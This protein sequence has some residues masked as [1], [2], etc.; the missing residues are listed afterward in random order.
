MIVS[1]RI[2]EIVTWKGFSPVWTNWCLF[3]F[4]LSTKAF[5]HSAQ[6]CTRGPWV[7]RCFLMAEL[8]LNIFV[9]PFKTTQVNYLIVKAS[10]YQN[11]HHLN[12]YTLTR[13]TIILNQNMVWFWYT[14]KPKHGHCCLYDLILYEERLLGKISSFLKTGIKSF[15]FTT[16]MGSACQKFRK[17]RA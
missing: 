5:P 3:S 16:A 2:F 8:S 7:C 12:L 4:E 1:S 10:K 11:Y 13:L 15:L 6:T 17:C 9:Q 14:A